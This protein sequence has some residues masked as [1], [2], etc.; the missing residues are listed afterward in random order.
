MDGF[1]EE[2]QDALRREEPAP[3]FG[4]RVAARVIKTNRRRSGWR[5]WLHPGVRWATAVVL[6]LA[7]AGGVMRFR[8]E[9]RERAEGE[10]ARQQVMFALRI[11][12]TKIRL[13]QTKIQNL[14]EPEPEGVQ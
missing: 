8:Q 12:G 7:I 9:R 11:A 4:A 10:A 2:L 5:S 14:A 6:P 13:A 3:A 1:E